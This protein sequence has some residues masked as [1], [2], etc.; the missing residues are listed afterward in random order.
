MNLS[1]SRPGCHA[2]GRPLERRVRQRRVAHGEPGILGRVCPSATRTG[3]SS[4]K[5]L[6]Q[7]PGRNLVQAPAAAACEQARSVEATAET[8][9][10]GACRN[11][12]ASFSARNAR[13]LRARADDATGARIRFW[14]ERLR[15]QRF[16]QSGFHGRRA[17]GSA[18]AD[19][20][21]PVLLAQLPSSGVCALPNV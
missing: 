15:L 12:S 2:V 20:S 8:C 14:H 6:R 19:L 10:D 18:R 3:S 7:R 13:L 9:A 4:C 5:R 17:T 16:R 1:A 11:S 21:A